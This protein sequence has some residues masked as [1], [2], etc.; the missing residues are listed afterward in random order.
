MCV[1]LKTRTGCWCE[2]WGGTHL[3]KRGLFEGLWSPFHHGVKRLEHSKH[4]L[5]VPLTEVQTWRLFQALVPH[6]VPQDRHSDKLLA[7]L[8][9]EKHGWKGRPALWQRLSVGLGT[10]YRMVTFHFLDCAELTGLHLIHSFHRAHAQYFWH[11]FLITVLFKQQTSISFLMGG[12]QMR[13][14]RWGTN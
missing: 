4:A 2:T 9:E 11:A 3:V 13:R 6:L 10:K 8:D 7:Y 14:H 5:D 1:V 12:R